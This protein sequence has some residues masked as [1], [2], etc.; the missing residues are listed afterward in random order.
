MEALQIETTERLLGEYLK[1]HGQHFSGAGRTVVQTFIS[2]SEPISIL[3]LAFSVKRLD[4]LVSLGT[5]RRYLKL[6]TEAGLAAAN[7][8]VT[9]TG[10]GPMLFGLVTDPK[11]S[12]GSCAHRHLACKDCGAVIDAEN[13]NAAGEVRARN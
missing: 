8:A 3:D 9:P 1:R 13:Q 11:P 2:A 6:L 10:R 12:S 4:P 7:Q 5:V